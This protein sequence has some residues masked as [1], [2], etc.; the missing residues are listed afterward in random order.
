MLKLMKYEFRKMR[1]TLLV[2]LGVLAALEIG[3]IVG[4]RTERD[5]VTAICVT[6]LSMLA[7]AVYAYILVAGVV[8][9]SRELKEKSG[10]LIFLAPVRPISVVCSKLLFSA[11]AALAATAVFGFAAFLDIRFLLGRVNI[12]AELIEQLDLM[13]RIGLDA[14]M[15]VFQILRATGFAAL[16]VL[17]QILLTMCC[18]YLA[19]TLSATLL[20]NRKGFLRGLISV[21]LFC[22]L[23]WGSGWLTQKLID[24]RAV[25]TYGSFEQLTGLL[26]GVLL[27][28]LSL[29]AVFAAVSAWLL[30]RRVNL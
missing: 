22:A 30:D 5:A 18:A 4:V 21:A 27:L 2:M 13:L 15:S 24:T 12:T 11:L 20:Q 19:I 29:S 3:F 25:G 8:S 7:F 23:S 17:I 28:D 26:S 1:G 10:Y 14:N 9:Y 16:T 6:L